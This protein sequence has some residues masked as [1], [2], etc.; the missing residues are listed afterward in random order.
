MSIKKL[1]A[2]RA[3]ITLVALRPRR[4]A[5]PVKK[6]D[7]LNTIAAIAVRSPW[8]LMTGIFMTSALMAVG[9]HHTVPAA[10]TPAP[11]RPLRAGSTF[12]GAGG[13]SVAVTMSVTMG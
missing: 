1:R 4:P 5:F 12:V 13:M 7:A 8:L 9:L 6:C 10:R 2:L 11:P 3:L